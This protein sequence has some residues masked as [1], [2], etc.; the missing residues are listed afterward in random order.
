MGLETETETETFRDV[1]RQ[2][3]ATFAHFFSVT[4]FLRPNFLRPIP[5]LFFRDQ[6]FRY[7]YRDFS[8]ETKFVDTDTETFFRDLI[9]RYRYRDF[10]FETKF[11]DTDTE[12]TNWE[13]IDIGLADWEWIDIE[14][15]Y[16]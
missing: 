10:F 11:S 5:K 16:W 7:Q 3:L 1:Y 12:T 4:F 15:A 6:I 2:V 14:V 13:W 9:F 8:N